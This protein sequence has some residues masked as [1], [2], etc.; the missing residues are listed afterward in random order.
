[1]KRL[2]TVILLLSSSLPFRR[3]GAHL[4]LDRTAGAPRSAPPVVRG[5]EQ[6]CRRRGARAAGRQARLRAR[7]SAGATRKPTAR[8]RPDTIFRIASQT[9]AITS[10]AIM[11]L[12][13]EGKIGI[14]RSGEPLHPGVRQDDRPSAS[15]A[16]TTT[17]PARR[18]ITI[19]DLL[20]HT[21]GISY[22]TQPRPRAALPGEGA[23]PR[24]RL[25]L[26][27]R[28]QGRAG[29]R[30]DG[31]ARHAAVSWRSR[32]RRTSTATTPTSSAASSSARRACRSISSSDAHH[33]SARDEG[34][35]V[36]PA[37]GQRDRLAAVY[38]ERRRAAADRAR[39][40]GRERAGRTTST[41]R[42]RAS[43]AAPA[44]SRRR[45]T[46][47]A[48]SKRCATAA[49]STACASSRRARWS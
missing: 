6:H 14:D 47:R 44:C 3:A 40:G 36:L 12:V 11:A 32:A 30:H 19:R 21:A 34:H 46:T 33:R 1:M 31:A 43:P 18:A 22:G 26:V 8:W 5:R 17:V 23:R 27:H 37:A 29:L 42:A 28:R 41:A 7:R 35:A 39:T 38:I 45:A 13:E 24:G 10:V 9:K 25:R 15:D 49:C 16:G 20:T 2:L 48:S 4:D